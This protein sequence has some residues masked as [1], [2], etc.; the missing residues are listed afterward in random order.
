MEAT[1]IALALGRIEATLCSMKE[2]LE[3]HDNSDDDLGK[4]IEKLEQRVQ[5][6]ENANLK[7]GTIVGTILFLIGLLGGATL[8]GI[9]ELGNLF[10]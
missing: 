1:E 5:K 9:A 3:D 7:V 6:I 4:K 10:K 2:K 8:S